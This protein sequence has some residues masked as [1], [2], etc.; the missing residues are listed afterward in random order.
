MYATTKP[1]VIIH[2]M[3]LEHQANSIEAIHARYTLTALT[4]NLDVRGGEELRGTHPQLRK[5]FEIELNEKLSPEQ[6]EKQI[7]A[8]RFKLSS[9]Y[10]YE[11]IT[12]TAKS[13]PG[14]SYI[15]FAHAPS[16][17]QAMISGEPYPVKALVTVASNPLV[18]QTNVKLVYKAIKSLELYL[19]HDFWLTPSAEIADY[20]LPCASWLERPSIF[21][22][23]DSV[24]FVYV[25]GEAVSIF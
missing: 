25:V 5:E 24:S 3:G 15:A 10:G 14:S 13:S 18:T 20:V 17:Y 4:G 11:L 6:K 7:G 21:S 1:G 16:V 8:E 9:K 22:Y 23:W 2:A 12:K 19:V